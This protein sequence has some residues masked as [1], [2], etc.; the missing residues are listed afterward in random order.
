MS[1]FEIIMLVCFG[2]S[3]PFSIV[4][5]YRSRTTRGK[6]L[7]FLIMVFIGYIGGITHKILYRP[8][9]VLYL[10]IL[11]ETMVL[12]DIMMYFRNRNLMK[13]ENNA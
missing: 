4:K 1:V 7:L 9:S 13:K 2:F 12:T 10:Y 3:W 11:N 8:D 5:S 6:S